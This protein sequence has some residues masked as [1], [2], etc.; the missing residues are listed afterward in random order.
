M[1]LSLSLPRIGNQVQRGIIHRLIAKAGDDLRPGTPLFEL[2]VDLGSDKMQDC[3]PLIFFRILATERAHLRRLDV[4]PGDAR[5][6]TAVLGI[7]TTTGDE[8]VEGTPARTL[9]T[10]A[11]AIQMDPLAR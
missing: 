11:V 10:T 6:V 4:S 3:P 7:A 2:R 8:S 9:R 5:D 1:I